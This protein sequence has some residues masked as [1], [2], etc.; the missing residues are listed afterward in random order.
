MGKT[1]IFGIDGASL[2]LIQSWREELPTLKRLMD[3]GVFGELE[4]TIPPVTAPAWPCMFTGKNPAKLGMYSFTSVRFEKD[5]ELKSSSS[6]S[7]HSFSLW[8]ILNSYGKKVGLLNVPIT[9]PPHKVDSFIVCGIGSPESWKANYTYPPELKRTL[10]RLVGG[11]EIFPPVSAPSKGQE[12]AY[13]EALRQTILKRTKAAK[14]LIKSFPWD[15]FICVFWCLDQVQHFFWH[16]MDEEHPWHEV[17]PLKDS[18]KEFYKQI[19]TSIAEIMAELPSDVDILV[20]SDHGFDKLPV[21]FSVVKWLENNGFLKFKTAPRDRRVSIDRL[22]EAL[23]SK[24]S[25]DFARL[26]IKLLP[27]RLLQALSSQAQQKRLASEPLRNVDWSR[28]KAYA[29]QGMISINL[30]GREP[31][32]IVE[33]GREYERVRDE[34]VSKLGRLAD[35]ETG[36]PLKIKVFKREEIYEGK[37]LDQAPDILLRLESYPKGVVGPEWRKPAWS[38]WHSPWGIFIASGPNIRKSGGRLT[39][40]KIYDITP[41]VLHLFG[42][43]L[44]DDLDGRVL[45]EI[46]EPSSKV[47]KREVSYQK[48]EERLRHKIRQLKAMGRI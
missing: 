10:D 29:I 20:V 30:R 16:H 28:T 44:P 17:S 48:V 23:L 2:K 35:P 40:L 39:N 43:P 33:P 37:Y 41:T 42:L 25:P 36:K 18:I 34:I 38:G 45:T 21:S 5:W 27:Q 11:Y 31:E 47:A 1:V 22:K 4:S 9:Y 32:G 46:F 6:R 13:L 19:D 8:K 7:Y 14:F 15:L 26:L 3:G 12:A 24:M